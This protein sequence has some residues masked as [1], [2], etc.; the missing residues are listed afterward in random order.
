MDKYF[1]IKP[2]CALYKVIEDAESEV[3][4]EGNI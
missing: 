2:D 4:N 3:E 1:E